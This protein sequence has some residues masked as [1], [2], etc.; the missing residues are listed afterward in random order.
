MS[1]VH[2]LNFCAY[3]S[4]PKELTESKILIIYLGAVRFQEE[5]NRNAIITLLADKKV[6]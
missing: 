4:E 1:Q 6:N 5:D 3:L 2:I